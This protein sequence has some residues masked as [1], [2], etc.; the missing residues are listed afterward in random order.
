MQKLRKS[1]TIAAAAVLVAGGI[2]SRAAADQ[3]ETE[4]FNRTVPFHAGGRFTLNNFSGRVTI[5][6]GD[7]NDIV[8]HAVRRATRERLDHIRI[9]VKVDASEVSIEANRKDSDWH[10]RDDNVVDTDF[11][12]QV[13]RKTD[14]DVKVFSSRVEVSGVEGSQRLR[15]F[16]GDLRVTEATGPMDAETFSGDIDVAFQG[17]PNG[18][19]DFDSFSGR[20]DSTRPIATHASSRRSRVEGE[21]G[22]GGDTRFRFKTFSG[23]VTLR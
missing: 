11:E 17:S 18:Q 10:E 5:T 12:I 2:A 15:T 19:L 16:S 21:L 7:S 13:P 8:I 14:L 1:M 3:R 23:D 4:Q 22:S 20:L 9:D 6:G